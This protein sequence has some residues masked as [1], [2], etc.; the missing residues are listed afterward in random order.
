MHYNRWFYTLYGRQTR[1]KVMTN[2]GFPDAFWCKILQR[3]IEWIRQLENFSRLYVLNVLKYLTFSKVFR[4]KIKQ[5][6]SSIS[7]SNE[8]LP[9][10]IIIIICLKRKL[11]TCVSFSRELSG[12]G[13]WK[14]RGTKLNEDNHANWIGRFSWLYDV[15]NSRLRWKQLPI[16]RNIY[17]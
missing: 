14:T 1:E 3:N 2:E 17:F 7:S 16:S 11:Y 10:V 12:K 9:F 8:S 15:W 6:I 4:L 13:L 5:K